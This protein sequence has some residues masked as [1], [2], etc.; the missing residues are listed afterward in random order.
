VVD[1]ADDEALVP[2]RVGRAADLG[3]QR[4]RQH[5]RALVDAHR[6]GER[7]LVE[8]PQPARHASLVDEAKRVA[9]V[10]GHGGQVGETGAVLTRG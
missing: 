1:E 5:A 8:R 10:E 9:C 6:A 7:Q 3:V 4:P 2:R